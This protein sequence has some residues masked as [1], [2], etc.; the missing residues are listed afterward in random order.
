M[1]TRIGVVGIVINN[2]EADAPRVNQ[3]LSAYGH[4]ILGRMGIPNHVRKAAVISLIVEGT[5]D[6]IG[7]LTG[8]LGQI[9]NVN[10]KSA[11]AAKSTVKREGESQ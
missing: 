1:E 3:I 5:T 6:E 4:I 9:P 8:K 10:T 2:P 7:A 11:L